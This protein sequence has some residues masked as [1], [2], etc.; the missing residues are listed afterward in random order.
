[1]P[2]PEGERGV[3][4]LL[5]VAVRDCRT[6]AALPGRKSSAGLLHS[7]HTGSKSNHAGGGGLTGC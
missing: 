2:A 1:M 3:D 6:L 4:R 5:L 7:E